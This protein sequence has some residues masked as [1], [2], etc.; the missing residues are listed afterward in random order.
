MLIKRKFNFNFTTTY[1]FVNNGISRISFLDEADNNTI[2][3]TYGNVG[4]TRELGFNTF[5]QWSPSSKTRLMLNGGVRYNRAKQEGYEQSR[6]CP[7][8]YMQVSQQLPF[9]IW[10]ELSVY[11]FGSW[12][13]G[14][15]GYSNMS[16][17]DMLNYNIGLRRS[18]LKEDRLSISLTV[19]NPIGPGTRAYRNYTVNG[20]YTGRSDSYSLYCHKFMVRV[21][22]RFG[23]LNTQVKKTARS[24]ENDDL[25]GRK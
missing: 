19:A 15:Y 11:C 14:V 25:V 8:G 7:Q 9:K 1:A 10:T 23:S 4:H 22:Y 18:F 20:Q 16:F 21:S 12:M 17:A 2:V 13:N 5:V 24:I 6:W 3:N